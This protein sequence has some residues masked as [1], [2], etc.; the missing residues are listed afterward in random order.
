M[1]F[2]YNKY[3]L[4]DSINS[5]YM[6]QG[7]YERDNS[8]PQVLNHNPTHSK[9]TKS[10][11]NYSNI[12]QLND[13]ITAFNNTNILINKSKNTYIC[14]TWYY[15]NILYFWEHNILKHIYK[16]YKNITNKDQYNKHGVKYE[17][18]LYTDYI[19]FLLDEHT[20][21]KQFEIIQKLLIDLFN[22]RI[23]VYIILSG[24]NYHNFM[25]EKIIYQMQFYGINLYTPFINIIQQKD[26][27]EMILINSATYIMGSHTPIYDSSS[28]Q[29]IQNVNKFSVSKYHITNSMYLE[30]VKNNGYNNQSYWTI[31]GWHYLKML[32]RYQPIYWQYNNETNKWYEKIFGQMYELRMNNPVIHIS[33]YEASAYCKWKGCRLL[34]EIEWEYIAQ[35]SYNINKNIFDTSQTIENTLGIVGLFNNCYEW[36]NDNFNPYDGFIKDPIYPEMSVPQFGKTKVVRGSS[37]YSLNK[38]IDRHYRK[39][40]DPECTIEYIGF[41]VAI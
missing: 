7:Y 38:S 6:T 24:Y 18:I 3:K 22:D 16:N 21:Y 12:L 27:L 36:C 19:P 29:S 10:A 33:W 28:P 9:V 31:D 35:Y 17:S 20:I 2:L 41:R 25:N 15:G 11:L 4:K 40:V 1:N 23:L 39:G 32:Q 30:F 14:F 34:N 13:I 8:S 5:L 37:Y 26:T